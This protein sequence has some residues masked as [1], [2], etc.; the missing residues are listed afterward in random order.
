MRQITTLVFILL[1]FLSFGQKKNKFALLLH[2]QPEVTFHKNDY[3]F[4]WTEKK[5]VTT[6][7][8]GLNSSLQYKLTQRFFSD[9][10]LGY[11]S[12]KLN[13]K[14]F[15]DQSLL[16]PPYYDSTLILYVTKSVAFRTLQFPVGIGYNLVKTNKTS[17]FAKGIYV[18]N[19]ILNTKYKTNNYPAFKKDIWQGYSINLGAGLDYVLRKG[20]AFTSLLTYSV[21]NTVAR[22]NYTFSQDER[23]I[24]L[25]H[26]Y[27]QL[28]IG[29]KIN[30]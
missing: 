14:V 26:D 15:L 29:A 22:D 23:R 3:A 6:F 18:P 19:F 10:G 11:I 20:M 2:V 25:T 27:L 13:T 8:V 7:N 5:T 17:L 12:R 4:R 1:S 9:F 24:A 28:S 30:L 21:K 16:P